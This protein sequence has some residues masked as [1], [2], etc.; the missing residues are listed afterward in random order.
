MAGIAFLAEK[1]G[2]LINSFKNLFLTAGVMLVVNPLWITDLGFILSF[3]SS[4]SIMIFSR[5]ILNFLKFVP[6]VVREDL[7]T[8]LSAQIGVAPILFVTFGQFSLLSPIVNVLVL[9]TVPL[10]MIVGSLG[11]V[12]GLVFPIFGKLILYISYP[13]GWWFT[14]V[15]EIFA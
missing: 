5:K 4:A 12:I 7:S 11:G 1:E 15:V 13:L 10:I 14:K 6:G 9:W 2:R 8:T 3:V